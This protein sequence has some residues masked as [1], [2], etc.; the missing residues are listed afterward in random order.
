VA[1]A[2]SKEDGMRAGSS[3]WCGVALGMVAVTGCAPL[4]TGEA[5]RSPPEAPPEAPGGASLYQ[6]SARPAVAEGIYGVAAPAVETTAPFVEVREPSSNDG[7]A[8]GPRLRALFEPV[9]L[10]LQTPGGPVVITVACAGGSGALPDRLRERDE[11]DAPP[12]AP[13]KPWPYEGQHAPRLYHD[14]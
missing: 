13:Y 1:S 4:F 5:S 9:S 14:R 7:P 12:P 6:S 8:S 10:V 11:D 2:G 3:A